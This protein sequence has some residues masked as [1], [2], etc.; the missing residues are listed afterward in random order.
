MHWHNDQLAEI[1]GVLF[2]VDCGPGSR[3]KKSTPDRFVLL[4]YRQMLELVLDWASSCNATHILEV[5]LYE[6]GT[7]AFYQLNLQPAKLASIEANPV[8]I[9]AIETFIDK[10]GLRERVHIH[11]GTDQADGAAI[12]RIVEQ[13]LDG[14]LCMVVDDAS[15]LYEESKA[16]F[17]AAFPLLREGGC[18]VIEDWACA[19]LDDE[20]W[21]DYRLHF[22]GRPPLT[23]LG[24]EICMLHGSRP[25]LIPEV[26]FRDGMILVRKGRGT[27][28]A[29]D[30]DVSTAYRLQDA[31]FSMTARP[32]PLAPLGFRAARWA[33][34]HV[35]RAVG[36][37]PRPNRTR[38]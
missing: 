9:D 31:T 36:R 20:A 29:D 28:D 11:Y 34:R 12:R 30:F 5:G 14:R 4:K 17:N 19:H 13:D 18:Y 3:D 16:T 27:I 15:H 37:L 6:A 21:S 8:P 23:R 33:W 25:E 24:F 26:V 2:D 7:C 32:P 1:D 38:N 35:S 10:R 22:L